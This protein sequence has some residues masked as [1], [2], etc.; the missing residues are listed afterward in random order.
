MVF[1]FNFWVLTAIVAVLTYFVFH[2][3]S[4]ISVVGASGVV[5]G[6][7]GA[8]ARYDFLWSYLEGATQ[9]ERFLSSLLSIKK[10]CVQGVYLFT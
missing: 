10:R 6:M 3:E 8:I 9:N 7:M 5:S 4:A 1:V 2:Q